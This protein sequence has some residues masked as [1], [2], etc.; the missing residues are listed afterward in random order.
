MAPYVPH[1]WT[2]WSY[3][4][5]KESCQPAPHHEVKFIEL[6]GPGPAFADNG[7]S[8]KLPAKHGTWPYFQ[9]FTIALATLQSR[10]WTN[11]RPTNC[12][13]RKGFVI[14]ASANYTT[15]GVR[16]VA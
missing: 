16:P 6:R 3:P 4:A 10:S 12:N 14:P 15:N 2:R 11:G 9:A 7:T 1:A 13:T 8:A 5:I